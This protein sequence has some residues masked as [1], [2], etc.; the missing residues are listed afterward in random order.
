MFILDPITES[1]IL[2]KEN[3]KNIIT[4][5]ISQIIPYSIKSSLINISDRKTLLNEYG[6]DSFIDPDNLRY[7]VIN[8]N[9]GK[10]DC[11]LIYAAKLRITS[12]IEGVLIEDS[13]QTRDD[14]KDKLEKIENLYEKCG[15]NNSIQ[16]QIDGVDGYHDLTDILKIFEI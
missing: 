2:N 5:A 9:T 7:P 14:I 6:I 15:C 3:M 1:D 11:N 4:E 8:P 12:I 10:Y 16:I 13:N